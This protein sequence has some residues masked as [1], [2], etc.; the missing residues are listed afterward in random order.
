MIY[1][2]DTN[3]A[4]YSA[5][6]ESQYKKSCL[7]IMEALS[8]GEI[9]GVTSVEVYQEI[10]YRYKSL[11]LLL[12]GV[13]LI[14]YLD[15]LLIDVLPVRQP[16]IKIAIQLMKAHKNIKCRDAIHAAVM[17]SNNISTIISTDSHFDCIDVIKRIDPCRGRIHPTRT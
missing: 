4:M 12:S 13:K 14:D 10:L 17:I 16:D 7:S 2:I 5:G 8:N 15:S 9:R 1:F 11:R 3:I 6:K